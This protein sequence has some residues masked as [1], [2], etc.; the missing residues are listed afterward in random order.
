M[1]S[2]AT[3]IS[4]TVNG[5]R[6]EIASGLML[7]DLLRGANID[8]EQSGIAVAVNGAVVRRVDWAET[9]ISEGDE[10][11]IITATQGG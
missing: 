5:E 9:P 11:E 4:V 7:P 6:R 1:M 3:S 10:I 8:P 2:V